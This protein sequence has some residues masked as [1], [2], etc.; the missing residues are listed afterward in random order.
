MLVP[1][2]I[3]A[4]LMFPQLTRNRLDWHDTGSILFTHIAYPVCYCFPIKLMCCLCGIAFHA[5]CRR[6][7]LTCTTI[8]A[9]ANIIILQGFF[10]LP[11]CW[12]ITNNF[13][14]DLFVQ[15]GA[16]PTKIYRHGSTSS[17]IA[18]HV[19]DSL[20]IELTHATEK[21]ILFLTSGNL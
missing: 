20:G 3:L 12:S 9:H 21:N 17:I 8:Q 14:L 11:G 18:N 19:I 2:R 4:L 16:S 7:S 5:N 6:R 13:F 10:P 1:N 15:G